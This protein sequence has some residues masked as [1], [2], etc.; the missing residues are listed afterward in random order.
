MD[1]VPQSR[2]NHSDGIWQSTEHSTRGVRHCLHG[3]M[4]EKRRPSLNPVVLSGGR[5]D[6]DCGGEPDW[7]QSAIAAPRRIAA[8]HFQRASRWIRDYSRWAM[9]S[10]TRTVDTR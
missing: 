5:P 10:G 4:D 1:W 3:Q 6:R 7:S 8:L 9:G 2:L